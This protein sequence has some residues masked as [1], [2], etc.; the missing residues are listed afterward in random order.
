[1]VGQTF[2]NT[3]VAKGHTIFMGT[4][5]V[6][7]TLKKPGNPAMNLPPFADWVA[8]HPTVQLTSFAEAA[9][10]ADLL[11]NV[12]AGTAS[13]AALE[14]ISEQ[15]LAGKILIDVA[16]PLDFSKGMPPTLSIV[17]NDSLGETIQRQ[18]PDLKVVK[19]LNTMNC[20]V[21]VNPALISG[22]HNVFV[23][24]NDAAAKQMVSMFLTEQFGWT[25]ASIIDL[26]DI[27]TAR[28]TEQ[29]LPIW[30]RLWGAL[31]TPMF[32]FAITRA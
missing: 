25:P 26:G 31:Q 10:A 8:A 11:I 9:A 7:D 2:A 16:N 19:T 29:L 27:T 23:S 5:H 28:G 24:G 3:L 22:P 12:T 6:A 21:M 14:T 13:V 32:N 15:N 30:I 1:M 18:F 4:R 20:F 17:N